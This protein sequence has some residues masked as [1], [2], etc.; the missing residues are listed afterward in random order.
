MLKAQKLPDIDELPCF[1]CQS[2]ESIAAEPGAEVLAT[3]GHPYFD[4]APDHF[5][6]HKHTP[7]GSRTGGP[8]IVCNGKVVYIANPFFRSYGEDGY[9]IQE[10]VVAQLIRDLLPEPAIRVENVPSTA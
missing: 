6:S 4:R 3:Y 7:I 1:L 8:L 10:Q 9:G 5:S 2:G